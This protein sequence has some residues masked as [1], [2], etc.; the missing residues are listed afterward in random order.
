MPK[1]KLQ[2][3]CAVQGC[4]NNSNDFR[5]LTKIAFEK[6]STRKTLAH[7]SSLQMHQQ[8]CFQHYMQIVEGDM[9]KKINLQCET[10]EQT[11]TGKL[12]Q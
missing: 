10:S 3:P 4:T 5:R 9:G 8:I 7:Y 11:A 1:A 6:A 12:L 2:G